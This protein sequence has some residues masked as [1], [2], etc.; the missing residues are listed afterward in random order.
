V[1]VPPA[2]TQEAIAAA[3]GA[4]DEKVAIHEQLVETTMALRDA[5]TP[6]LFAHISD[7]EAAGR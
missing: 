3:L 7:I 2:E 5:V 1:L 4:L 6:L